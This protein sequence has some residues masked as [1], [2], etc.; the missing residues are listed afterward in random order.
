MHG[1]HYRQIVTLEVVLGALQLLVDVFLLQ[2]LC[3]SVGME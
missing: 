2:Y 1:A 3:H